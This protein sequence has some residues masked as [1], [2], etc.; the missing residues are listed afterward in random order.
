[1]GGKGRAAP[2]RLGFPP[3]TPPSEAPPQKRN[4]QGGTP[5]PP[6][7]FIGAALRAAS[8]WGPWGGFART[9]GPGPVHARDGDD[10]ARVDARPL[11]IG[12]RLWCPSA[13]LEGGSLN[14]QQVHLDDGEDGVEAVFIQAA[15]G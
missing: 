14:E 5:I 8:A 1:M 11:Q 6:R 13:P 15:S 4:P 10:S 9:T 3:W 12:F 7:A 2:P